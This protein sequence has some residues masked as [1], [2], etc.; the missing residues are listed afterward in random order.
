[1]SSAQEGTYSLIVNDYDDAVTGYGWST[2]SYTPCGDSHGTSGPRLD[3]HHDNGYKGLVRATYSL[4]DL[5]ESGCFE[6]F[7]WHPGANY[8][9]SRYLPNASPVWVHHSR[10]ITQLSIDQ[11]VDGQQWNSLGFFE[12]EQGGGY[13]IVS[14]EGTTECDAATCYWIADAFKL[15]AVPTAACP[16]AP[17]PASPSL[18]PAPPMLPLPPGTPPVYVYHSPPP[19]P[20]DD[21][22]QCLTEC[23]CL[24][25]LGVLLVLCGCLGMLLFVSALVQWRRRHFL[26]AAFGVHSLPIAASATGAAAADSGESGDRRRSEH[27]MT[28]MRTAIAALP[29]HIHEGGRGSGGGGHG[30]DN[31]GNERGGDGASGTRRLPDQL[32]TDG[33][34]GGGECAICLAEFAAGDAVKRLP[35]NHSFHAQCIDTWLLGKCAH[36]ATHPTC[37]LCK[38]NALEPAVPAVAAPPAVEPGPSSA[39]AATGRPASASA[40]A[41]ADASAEAPVAEV[42]L[43]PTA[44]LGLQSQQ[45]QHAA[46]APNQTSV[47]IV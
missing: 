47:T 39:A 29:T 11:S 43:S 26:S 41:S 24:S 36:A 5:A 45:Q 31:G 32:P 10:G 18:P 42:R 13:I 3:F 22:H 1:M 28:T 20:C 34:L 16:P 27:E 9:C 7:E 33:E 44:E 46:A 15:E 37:P 14:N 23:G 8:E 2:G 4:R 35:C 38:A 40:D 12:F 21:G 25:S 17:P 6:L 30:G 19:T